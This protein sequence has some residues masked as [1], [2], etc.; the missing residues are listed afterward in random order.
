MWI[1][2]NELEEKQNID[3]VISSGV[4]RKD[5]TIFPTQLTDITCI[6]TLLYRINYIYDEYK[7]QL[8]RNHPVFVIVTS[9]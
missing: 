9:S 7:Q 8:R 6:M 3:N 1:P 4:S 2:Q 5:L